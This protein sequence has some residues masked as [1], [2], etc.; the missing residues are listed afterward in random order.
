MKKFLKKR[1]FEYC[2]QTESWEKD[3]DHPY[4]QNLGIIIKDKEVNVVCSGYTWSKEGSVP[5][6]KFHIIAVTQLTKYGLES[7]LDIFDITYDV[8][9]I[10]G[11][12]V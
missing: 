1:G 8:V 4:L 2:P 12:E 11:K 9:S 6:D 7:I 10:G 5:D 3:V